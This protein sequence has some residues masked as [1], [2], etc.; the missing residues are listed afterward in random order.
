[1]SALHALEF[2]DRCESCRSQSGGL[3]SVISEAVAQAFEAVKY[4]CSYP[5]G[6][7]LL[8]EGQESGG[9]FL[10]CKGRV[11]LTMTGADAKSVI[12]RIAEPGEAIGLE[13][14]ISGKPSNMTAETFDPCVVHFVKRD[15][16]RAL[17]HDHH[18]LCVAIAEQ[19]SNDYRSA[20]LHI[21]SLGLS[22]SA[23]ER[24]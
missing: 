17:M 2:G 12:V 6:A 7:W 14:A 19:L 13:C 5:A 8:L 15:A 16:V 9:V 1:M 20:C 10:L 24:I 21:R 11:K 4:T 23:S 18:T 22:R 3:L